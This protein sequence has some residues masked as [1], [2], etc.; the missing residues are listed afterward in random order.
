VKSGFTQAAMGCLVLAAWRP[1]D[2]HQVLIMAAVTGQT[3]LEPLENAAQAA[4]SL[5]DGA[6]ASLR[7]VPVV[8]TS[9]RVA[10]VTTSWRSTPVA[11]FAQHALYMV[12]WPGETVSRA[13]RWA[14]VRVGEA[15]GAKLGTMEATVGSE[16]LSVPVL[17]AAAI[18]GPSLAWRLE[19]P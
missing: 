9:R 3:G 8:T 13:V 17:G 12:V 14:R 6:A 11:G 19:H 10:S 7:D 5:I 16:H 15:S 1:V 2:G 4:E 18:R